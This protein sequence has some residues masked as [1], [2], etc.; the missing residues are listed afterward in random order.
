M[1][2]RIH[3]KPLAALAVVALALAGCATPAP[4]PPP[5]VARVAPPPLVAPLR[6]RIPAGT[7]TTFRAPPRDSY[8]KYLTPNAGLVTE[9]ALW[10]LRMG[11]N[12]A[13]LSCFDATDS[14]NAAYGNFLTLHKDRLTRANTAMDRLWEERAGRADARNARDTHSVEVYN[15][16]ALPTVVPQFCATATKVLTTANATPSDQLDNYATV[17]LAELE[18]PFTDFFASYDTYRVAVADWDRLYGRAPQEVVAAGPAAP[19]DTIVFRSREVTYD[20][21]SNQPVSRP[22]TGEG[23]LAPTPPPVSPAPTTPLTQPGS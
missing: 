15:F 23:T 1:T 16:F 20:P 12:V 18:G 22:V 10:H 7:A 17:G 9:E 11:L 21:V 4:P 14:V 13:A 6:P 19:G 5:Q 3:A 2:F 8:G